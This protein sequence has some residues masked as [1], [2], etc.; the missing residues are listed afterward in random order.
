MRRVPFSVISL[1]LQLELKHFATDGIFRACRK[2]PYVPSAP[3]L[4]MPQ[5]EQHNGRS[6]GRLH[7]CCRPVHTRSS[8]A[9]CGPSASGRWHVVAK[10]TVSPLSPDRRIEVMTSTPCSVASSEHR[11]DR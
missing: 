10:V 4:E 9:S 1:P 7:R 8:C 11:G 5:T 3:D 2:G 6:L